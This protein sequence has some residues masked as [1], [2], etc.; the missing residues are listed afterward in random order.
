VIPAPATRQREHLSDKDPDIGKRRP[1]VERVRQG[2]ATLQIER[3]RATGAVTRYL[4]VGAVLATLL[5][6]S[7][8]YF[9]L[10]YSTRN[11]LASWIPGNRLSVVCVRPTAQAL[12]T[13]GASMPLLT[14]SGYVVARREA[15]ISAKIQGI[16]TELNVDVG[17]KVAQG[18]VIARLQS[19]EF[20]ARILNSK[21][22]VQL[23]QTS[24]DEDRRQL[25]IADQLAHAQV[26]SLD[27]RDA[28]ESRAN[29]A[30]A[31]VAVAQA[32]LKTQEVLRE[33]TFIRAP[34]RGVVVKKMAEVGESV[35]PIPPGVN[36]STSSGAIVAIADIDHLEVQ[37]DVGESNIAKL[38]P[39][40]LAEVM[41]ESFPNHQYR[42]SLRQIVPTADRTK[43]TV[44]AEVTI[45]DAD[46]QLKPEMTAQVTFLED[47]LSGAAAGSSPTITVPQQAVVTRTGKT[48]IFE[49]LQ[50]T[51]HERTV[52]A[53]AKRGDQVVISQGLVG[54]E[55]LILQPPAKMREGDA[56]RVLSIR[57]AE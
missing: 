53:G 24:L 20:D 28:A 11:R 44:Q 6:V 54:G 3:K 18:Q 43:G 41:V 10:G 32:D 25:R 30:Q 55:L 16:L 52:I 8:G 13:A 31:S 29:A 45:L 22:G 42:G 36:I 34:F 4:V 57:G 5:V 48:V 50:G 21:A 17:T 15:V 40:I 33:D 14:A 2:L 27:Q 56:V 23:A 47:P 46:R 7:L 19:R 1:D 37:V 35:S 38:K 51:A 26:V 39:G 49:V 12:G 9:F